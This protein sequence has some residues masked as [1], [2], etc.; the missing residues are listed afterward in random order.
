MSQKKLL[1]ARVLYQLD[2][3][4]IRVNVIFRAIKKIDIVFGWLMINHIRRGH[5][6]KKGGKTSKDFFSHSSKT[7]Y[8]KKSSTKS[9]RLAHMEILCYC[10]SDN[11]QNRD[12]RKLWQN[13]LQRKIR[14]NCFGNQSSAS[15]TDSPWHTGKSLSEALTN[16]QHDD[17][18]FIELQVQ[19]MKIASSEHA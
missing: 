18:L 10:Q 15:N 1:I 6:S 7:N 17:R 2:D 14:K 5:L 16:P 4:R 11:V 3:N 19:Y 13:W 9:W 12:H 8:F